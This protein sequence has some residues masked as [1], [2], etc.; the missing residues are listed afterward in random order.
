MTQRDLCRVWLCGVQ[1]KVSFAGTY[2]SL[3]LHKLMV[4]PLSL[5]TSRNNSSISLTLYKQ[6]KIP[7]FHHRSWLP[8][9]VPF[10]NFCFLCAFLSMFQFFQ[11]YNIALFHGKFGIYFCSGFLLS[12][13]VFGPL[14]EIWKNKETQ[15]IPTISFYACVAL[16][17]ECW[18][19]S[20]ASHPKLI[21]YKLL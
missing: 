9:L 18:T 4:Y 14:S 3:W 1:R 21:I 5:P 7:Q 12:L 6:F 17:A 2:F 11:R 15:K 13:E 16:Q 20:I 10:K 8:Y 19:S